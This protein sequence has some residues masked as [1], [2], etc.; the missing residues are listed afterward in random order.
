MKIN[1]PHTLPVLDNGE[2]VG[3]I[4]RFQVV[5]A[6]RSVYGERLDV[7]ETEENLETA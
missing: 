6:L 1:K 5:K 7:V 2:L 3:V 4:S